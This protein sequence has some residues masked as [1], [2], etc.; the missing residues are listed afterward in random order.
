MV[1]DG[2]ISGKIAKDVFGVSY[3]T[4]KDPTEVV[5]ER[6]LA[7]VTDE[8]PIRAAIE[9]VVVENP[10]QHA[11]YRSGKPALLGFFVGKVL[12]A[13]GGKASPALVNRLLKERLD[14][15]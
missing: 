4:G 11:Q 3:S 12:Q 2:T 15:P 8:G 5:R 6:G 9:K 7:Q 13:T 1:K 14:K 10:D